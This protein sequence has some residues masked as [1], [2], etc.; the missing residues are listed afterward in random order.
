MLEAVGHQAEH[1]HGIGL[2]AAADIEIWMRATQTGS[3]L[4][5]K[6]EDFAGL[7]RGAPPGPSVVW[8]RLGNVTNAALWRSLE[9]ILPEIVAAIEAG[10]RLIVVE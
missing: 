3:A 10:E 8:I 6:D 1:V 4:L 5:T 7:V 9:P 2:G